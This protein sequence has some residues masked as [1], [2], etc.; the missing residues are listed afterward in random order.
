MVFVGGTLVFVVGMSAMDTIQSQTHGEKTEQDLQQFD[1]DLTTIAGQGETGSV[2]LDGLDGEIVDDGELKVTVSDGYRTD[3]ESTNLTTFAAED[4]GGNEY[5][6]QAGGVWE[7]HDDRATPMATPN[8]DYYQET[9][10]DEEVGRIDI[11]PL[12]LEGTVGSGEH[13]VQQ[14]QDDNSGEF[15]TLGND[16]DYVDHVTVEV[17]DTAYHHGWYSFLEDEFDAVD[18]SDVDDDCDSASGEVTLICHDESAESV[19]VVA[20]VDGDAPLADLVDIE[21]AVFGGLFLEGDEG[22]LRSSLDV[23]SYDDHDTA[24][25][26]T[27]DLFLANYDEYELANNANVS[28]LSVVNG[29]VHAPSNPKMSPLVYGLEFTDQSIHEPLDEGVYQ[30]NSD[31]PRGQSVGAELSEP[32]DDIDTIDDELERLHTEYLDGESEADG[33]VSATDDSSQEGLFDGASDINSLDSSDGD[34][35]VGVD[36]H[37]T[38]ELPSDSDDPSVS[39]T[40]T[41]SGDNQ[42]NFYVE[43]D[44]QLGNVEIEPDDR[45]DSLWVYASS[46]SQITID[47]D[48]QGV[49]YAPGADI[50]IAENVTIDGAVVAGDGNIE[51][52]QGSQGPQDDNIEEYDVEINFDESLRTETPFTDSDEDLYFEYGEQR[53]P[54]DATF[55][56]DRSGSMGPHNPSDAIDPYNPNDEEDI[57]ESWEPIPTDD[58]FRNMDGGFL[59]IGDE[60]DVELRDEDGNTERLEYRDYAHPDDWE[61]IRVHPDDHGG[62][63]GGSATLGLYDHPGNDPTSE[64]VDATRNFIGMMNETDGDRAGVYDFDRDGHV[65]HHLDDDLDAAQ[66]NVEGHADGGTN[67]ADGFELALNDYENYGEDDQ[68]RVTVLLSDGQNNYPED[69]AAMDAQVERAN[70]LNVTLYTVGLGGLEHDPIPEDELEEWAEQTGGSFHSTDD[71][72][73]LFDLFET[74]AEEEVEVDAEPEVEITATHERDVT[75]DYAVSASEQ[76]VEI[77]S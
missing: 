34:I 48:F 53:M 26:V 61:D 14:P 3:T 5:A 9:I 72:E 25:N 64:R 39:E 43:G 7:I 42:T 56:L 22:Q 66:A 8:I 4:D 59:G 60:S 45:A 23:N 52:N 1:A 77:D 11:S 17:T 36:E 74:I 10:D 47:D 40:L 38:L 33:E 65:L 28:G 31:E 27:D 51:S 67:M 58:P 54:L 21:P 46:E 73:E 32:F 18:E 71:A 19:T 15:D 50:D 62:L 13:T 16:M 29:E 68:E 2:Y 69:D 20:A 30:I 12:S 41:V 44:V 75:A 24:S 70:E 35:H 55:V 57:G 63:F 49:V 37:D 6:Y 76:V